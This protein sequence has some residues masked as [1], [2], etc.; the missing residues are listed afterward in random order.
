MD[1]LEKKDISSQIK[2]MDDCGRV[3]KDESMDVCEMYQ[4]NSK[5][6]VVS[7]DI[8]VYIVERNG[9]GQVVREEVFEE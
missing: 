9:I 7:K 3:K 2:E 4:F 6:G 5:G 1:I 8:I